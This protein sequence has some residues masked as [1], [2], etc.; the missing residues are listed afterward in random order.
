MR[1]KWHGQVVRISVL[2]F[3][4]RKVGWAVPTIGEQWPDPMPCFE[5]EDGGVSWKPMKMPE[6]ARIE[7][8]TVAADGTAYFWGYGRLYRRVR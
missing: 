6:S 7:G 3:A 2:R 1:L 4:N 8:A 5:T